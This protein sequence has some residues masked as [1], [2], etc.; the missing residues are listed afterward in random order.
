VA[1][2]QGQFAKQEEWERPSLEAAA[3][4]RSAI[5]AEFEFRY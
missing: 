4:Q 1:E 5:V 2:A 3:K